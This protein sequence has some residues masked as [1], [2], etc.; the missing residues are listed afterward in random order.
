MDVDAS[1]FALQAPPGTAAAAAFEPRPDDADRLANKAKFELELEVRTLPHA[2][3][4]R[5]RPVAG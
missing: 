1:P 5:R 3:V 4:P 2:P